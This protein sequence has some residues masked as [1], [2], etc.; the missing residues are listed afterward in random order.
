MLTEIKDISKNFPNFPHSSSQWLPLYLYKEI[1]LYVTQ[2]SNR[3][4][5][6]EDNRSY[7]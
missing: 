2:I 1:K 7:G 3:Q 5:Y 4:Q 6:K